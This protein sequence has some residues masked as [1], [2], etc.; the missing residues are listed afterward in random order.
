MNSS[1]ENQKATLIQ[2]DASY[3]TEINFFHVEAAAQAQV[4]ATIIDAATVLTEREGF[5]AVNVLLST[6]GS[7]ICTYIQ[8]NDEKSLK[9]AHQAIEKFWLSDFKK[10][11]EEGS[12]GPRLYDIYYTDDRSTGGISVI[13]QSY[14][15]TIFINEITTIPGAKQ[16]RLLELVVENNINQSL[17]TPGY[18][19]ANFHKSKDGYRAVNYS[20]WDSE[21]H[22]IQAIS[23]MADQDVNLEETVQLA[24]PDF[25]FY[26]LAFASHN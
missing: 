7:R 4:A 11:I 13:S 19:S 5:I 1:I 16:H 21:E 18:R 3:V 17:R 9:K 24:N 12:G 6:D 25:R 10:Q 23:E 20:L 26:T 15:G 14:T 22:L 8:W 2:K